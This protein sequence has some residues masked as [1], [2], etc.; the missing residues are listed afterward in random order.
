MKVAVS[1]PDELSQRA[2]E[3]ASR[4]GLSRSQLYAKAVRGF[5]EEQGDDPVTRKLDE[6]AEELGSG[7]GRVAGRQLIDQGAW[8]W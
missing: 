2:D 8:E 5:L 1:L 6:L 4:L 3:M 7:P